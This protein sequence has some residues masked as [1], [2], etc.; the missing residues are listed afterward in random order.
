MTNTARKSRNS[1]PR[2]TADLAM[3]HM[4]AKSLF[5]DVAR[6]GAGRGEYEAWLERHT[7]QRSAGKLSKS[8]RID[9]IRM[10]RREGLLP[11]RDRGGRNANRPTPGQWAKMAA[12]A[13]DLG[14]NSTKDV[15][16]DRRLVGF[17]KRTAK[18]DGLR[19]LT[20]ISASKVILGL[21]QMQRQAR[22][23][24]GPPDKGGG[25]AVP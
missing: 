23:V 1:D 25:D 11:E 9:L 10:I 24:S 14:W 21:E 3:I 18:V 5:G 13:R 6:G 20:R 17:V 15:L 19:F 2:R 4:A 7:G 16:D 22:A 12:I 8:A